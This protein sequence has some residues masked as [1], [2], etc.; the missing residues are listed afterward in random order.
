MAAFRECYAHLHELRSLAPE[1]PIIALTATATKLT[2]DT[3]LNVLL[4]DNPHEIKD[5]P[6]KL[7]LTYIVE[8]MHKDTDLEFYFGWLVDELKTKQVSCERTIIYCQTIKQ[9]GVV[10]GTVKGMLGHHM[11]A[12]NNENVLVEM[13]HS[14]TP[15]ANKQH[16]SLL[17]A[18]E[19]DNTFTHCNNCL[20]YGGGLQRSPQDCAL[21]TI[22]N[23]R[24]ICARNWTGW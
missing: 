24:S 17:P 19:W 7:N 18:R 13:L 6:N 23:S 1:V 4:M 11:Y 2:K 21:W 20:W 3:I 10:Y 14:C 9:C 16:S 12:G 22:K 8:C 5:S 15:A